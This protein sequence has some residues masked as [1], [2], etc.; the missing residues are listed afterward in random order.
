MQQTLRYLTVAALAALTL[1]ACSSSAKS[2]ATTTPTSP[3]TSYG[4]P[5]PTTTGTTSAGSTTTKATVS[6]A[7]TKL[8]TVLVD[9]EGKTLY[10]SSGDTK[11]GTSSCTGSCATIWPP[12]AVTGAATYGA[13]LTASKFTTITRSDGT[14]QLAYN[15]KPLYTF[16]SDAKPGDTTGQGVGGFT[17]A[18]A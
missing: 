8:G 10:T 18:K 14:K 4:A 17:V 2:S 13:G 11:P 15:G 16:A 5:T 1:V 12:L 6:T 9:S 3:A 7:T